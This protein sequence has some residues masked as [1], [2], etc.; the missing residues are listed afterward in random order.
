MSFALLWCESKL[1][2]FELGAIA[3]QME[4]FEFSLI[5]ELSLI[6]VSIEFSNF[7][8]SLNFFSRLALLR[9]KLIFKIFELGLIA[10]RT[11]IKNF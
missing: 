6:V 7:W 10:V 9:Y 5:F 8:L 3:V 11:D 2:I 4:V 1:L